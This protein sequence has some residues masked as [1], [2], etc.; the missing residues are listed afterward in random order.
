VSGSLRLAISRGRN[1]PKVVVAATY[2][3]IEQM[4]KADGLL[5]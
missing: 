1:G 3:W 5:G 4:A 2:E